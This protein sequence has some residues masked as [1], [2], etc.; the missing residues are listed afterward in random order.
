MAFVVAVVLAPLCAVVAAPASAGTILSYPLPV[1]GTSALRSVACTSPTTCVAVGVNGAGTRGV[2]ASAQVPHLPTSKLVRAASSLSGVACA[3]SSCLAVGRSVHHVGV[4]LPVSNGKPGA[5]VPVAGATDLSAVA[6]PAAG[7][8]VAVGHQNLD[9]VVVVVTGGV[10][11]PVQVVSHL[12]GGLDL[13]GIACPTTTSCF[14]VGTESTG[15]GTVQGALVAVTAGVAGPEQ[16]VATGG[17]GLR[18]ITCTTP[19][20]CVAVGTTVV[21]AQVEG[22]SVPVLAGHAV[23][24]HPVPAASALDG[25]ACTNPVQCLAVGPG[26]GSSSALVPLSS[27]I[28]QTNS[29]ATLPATLVAI[30][31]AGPGL[32]ESVGTD[33]GAPTEGVMLAA[34]PPTPTLYSAGGLDF[35]PIDT[36]TNAVGTRIPLAG[37]GQFAVT[38]TPDGTTALVPDDSHGTVIPVDLATHTV[39]PAIFVG[40]QPA[41]IAVTPDGHTAF[42]TNVQNTSVAVI[43]LATDTLTGSINV[44]DLTGPVV[45]APEGTTAYVGRALL[46]DVVPIDVVTHAVGTPIPTGLGFVMGGFALS[47]DGSTLYAADLGQSIIPI[48]RPHPGI[49]RPA[50]GPDLGGSIIPIDL[51]TRTIEPSMP[52]PTGVFA[53]APSPD[54]S[55]MWMESNQQNIVMSIDLS[56]HV[57][58]RLFLSTPR[59]SRWP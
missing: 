35:V 40:G 5:A 6:C 57:L 36:S 8:C 41:E 42:V 2:I 31:C 33:F 3:G 38:I 56:T 46:G 37:S 15:P 44:S 27:G 18:A 53:L 55:T 49:V 43:D 16:A 11:G 22:L 29:I 30:A 23:P 59:S 10:P 34:R 54:G 47:P 32:C 39:E 50:A 48:L 25:V 45:I 28:A 51:A 7:S 13:T 26:A 4:V 52:A 12:V 19:T 21:V 9:G 14:A 17:G 1:S 58:G 20:V 24:G